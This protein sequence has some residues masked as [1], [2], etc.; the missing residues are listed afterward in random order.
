MLSQAKVDNTAAV[1]SNELVSVSTGRGPRNWSCALS[2]IIIGDYL[3]VPLTSAKML[4]NEGSR[5]MNCCRDYATQCAKL[6]YC[7]FSI[8]TRSGERLATLGLKKNRGYWCFDQCFGPANVEVLEE[9][10][11]YVDEDG[12]PQ[13]ECYPT[14]LYYVAYDVV[15]MINSTSSH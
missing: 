12:V 13:T 3:I 2:E 10:L 11:E 1:F 8:R 15:R 7:I 9:T 5:M 14:E 6:K 4:K